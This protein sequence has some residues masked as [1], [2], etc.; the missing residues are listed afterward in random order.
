MRHGNGA[1]NPLPDFAARATATSQSC[2]CTPRV[3]DCA[4]AGPGRSE[5]GAKHAPDQVARQHGPAMHHRVRLRQAWTPLVR[6]LTSHR[7]LRAQQR[8]AKP[9]RV[10]G[11]ARHQQAIHGLAV[12]IWPGASY[13]QG[14]AFGVGWYCGSHNGSASTREG[15]LSEAHEL[16]EAY[17]AKSEARSAELVASGRRH[18]RR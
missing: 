5:V 14:K 2:T 13:A 6:M 12:L 7:N 8:A 10:S 17:I 9:T 15:K 18:I 3:P 11:F 1:L 4:S 16:L